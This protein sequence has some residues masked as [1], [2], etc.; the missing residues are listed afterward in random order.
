LNYKGLTANASG[1]ARFSGKIPEQSED[2]FS[3]NLKGPTLP[4]EKKRL[5]TLPGSFPACQWL[6]LSIILLGTYF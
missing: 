6:Y 4:S 1:K 5:P 3:R 2:D